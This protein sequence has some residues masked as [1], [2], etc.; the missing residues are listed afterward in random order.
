MRRILLVDDDRAFVE[1]LNQ[2]FSREG[3]SV[4]T[5][6]DAE[7]ALHRIKAWRPQ[8]LVLSASLP[9]VSMAAFIPRVRSATQE[10]FVS[11][12]LIAGQGEGVAGATGATGNDKIDDALL[13]L[14]SGADEFIGRHFSEPE[15]LCRVRT[16]LRFKDL[17]DSLRRANHRIDELSTTDE[18]TGML[19]MRTL[20]RKGE[21]EILRARRFKKPVSALI[22]NLDRFSA[23]NHQLG[24][25]SGSVII[26][27]VAN[28]IRS[29]IRSID[30]AARVGADEFFILLVESDLANAEF[31]AER[32]RD[33]IQSNPYK[34]A[35]YS[36]QLTACIGVAGLPP[37]HHDQQMS[38]LFHTASEALRSAKAIG[39]NH[40]EIY[41]F[42]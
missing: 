41:S 36:T 25:A 39:P 17:Q 18:L 24:F 32:I 16:L 11:I 3:C 14:D 5:A 15:L 4:Q 21:E 13:G 31:M 29:S 7:S 33:A 2:I 22:V 40:I 8:L 23:V 12:L 35:K 27:E 6:T 28:R 30:M 10:D 26:Q 9:G 38:D 19:N 20:H 1:H 42:A 37:D 34:D